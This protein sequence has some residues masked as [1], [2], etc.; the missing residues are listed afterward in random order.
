M[1]TLT[2]GSSTGE[3][4][5]GVIRSGGRQTLREIL[6]SRTAVLG[7]IVVLLFVATAI[8]GPAFLVYDPYRLSLAERL[9]PPSPI[10]WMGTDEVGRDLLT[11][12]VV[13]ARVSL[14]VGFSA[15]LLALLSGMLLGTIAAYYR[16][17]VDAVIMRCMDVLL[18]FPGILLAITIVAALGTSLTNLIVAVGV[19]SVPVFARLAYGCTLSVKEYEYIQAARTIGASNRAILFRHI[20]PNIMSPLIVQASLRV[21]TVILMTAGLGFLGLGVQPP[22]PEW[23]TMLSDARSYM[24]TDPHVGFFPGLMIFVVVL[25]FN[26]LG[27]GLR[28]A[29]D[30]RLRSA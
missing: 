15:T 12:I 11:R 3:A 17:Y 23:G 21:G 4:C 14:L 5:A 9:Q 26:L 6:R 18:A 24:R 30:P 19:H 13:G 10:H 27:D 20:L 28:D 2:R 29:L 25:G 8:A 22:M 16:G 1:S 7:A